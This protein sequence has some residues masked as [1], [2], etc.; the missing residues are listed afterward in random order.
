M[1]KLNMNERIRICRRLKGLSQQNLADALGCTRQAISAWEK[2]LRT[3]ALD[4]VLRIAEVLD[5]SFLYLSGLRDDVGKYE[6]D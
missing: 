1:V 5:C 2:G 6:K 3:P 4:T